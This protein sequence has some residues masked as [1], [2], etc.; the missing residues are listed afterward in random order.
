MDGA[1]DRVGMD[2]WI[3]EWTN[4]VFRQISEYGLGCS[5]FA[6]FHISGDINN[7]RK[8]LEFRQ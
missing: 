1:T 5:T 2:E 7:S 6:F 3:E 4:R 8:I